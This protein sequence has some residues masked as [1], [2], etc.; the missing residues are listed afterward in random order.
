MTIVDAIDSAP[1]EHAVYFLV[2]AYIESLRHFERG[3]GVPKGAI[4]LP[5][6]GASDLTER[7]EM[8][9][10]NAD[11]VPEYAV[12][13]S[14]AAAVLASALARLSSLAELAQSALAAAA[15]RPARTDSRHSSLSV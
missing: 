1:T 12:A 15:M 2:T 9:R 7:L 11:V 14:E 13:R 4:E 5:V 3:C 10:S 8:L 6:C